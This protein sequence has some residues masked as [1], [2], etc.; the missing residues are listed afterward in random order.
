[1]A[2]ESH[3]ISKFE[4]LAEQLVEGTFGRLFAGRLHPLE[5]ATALARATEDAAVTDARGERLAP[6]IYWVYLNPEDYAALQAA[7]PTLPE[8]LAQSVIQLAGQ[9]GMR[10]PQTPVVEIHSSEQIPRRRVSAAARYVPPAGNEAGTTEQMDAARSAARQASPPSVNAFLILY[11][12][13]TI[14]LNKPI[15]ALGRSFDNDVV[16]D[17]PRVSRRHAQIRQ[18]GGRNVLYDLGSAGG[19]L[20]NGVRISEHVL[21]SGNVISLAGVEIIYGEDNPTPPAAPNGQ[22]TPAM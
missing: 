17:D 3:P 10:L 19:T 12:T 4:A 7:H 5:V 8:D 14:T 15:I 6:N 13:R 16:M 1:M 9:A 11:G 22:D 20:V 21:V 2:K 18:R